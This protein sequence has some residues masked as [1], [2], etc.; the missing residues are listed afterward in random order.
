M[1]SH[2]DNL[3]ITSAAGRHRRRPCPRP[4]SDPPAPTLRTTCSGVCRFLV[5]IPHRDFLPA[6]RAIR[7]SLRLDQQIGAMP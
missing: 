7:L 4:A 1:T 5:A 6:P 3:A 2:A